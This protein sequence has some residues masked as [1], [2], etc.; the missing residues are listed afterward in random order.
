[1]FMFNDDA[2]VT[3]YDAQLF[4][5]SWLFATVLPALVPRIAKELNESIPTTQEGVL[6]LITKR[7]AVD[8]CEA[9]ESFCVGDLQQYKTKQDCMKFIQVERPFGDIW[10][11]GQDTGI[12]RYIH[13]A[14]VPLR[15]EVHRVHI[16]PTGGGFCSPRNYT[17]VI[18]EDP[19][20][21]KFI[22]LPGN[23]SH[24]P[25]FWFEVDQT[26]GPVNNLRDWTRMFVY[27]EFDMY[28]D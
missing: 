2:K 5:S 10:Q 9:H 19:F 4:R 28:T 26:D 15:P 11:G 20:P 18:L 21:K 23:W 14:M 27:L 7:A 6:K 22:Q 13:K 3:Q 24:E 1:M 12:C 17:D 16:G 25:L 8:I